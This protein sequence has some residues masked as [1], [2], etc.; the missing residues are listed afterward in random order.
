APLIEGLH[1]IGADKTGPASDDIHAYS[2]FCG[3]DNRKQA[4]SY[5]VPSPCSFFRLNTCPIPAAKIR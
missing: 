3:Y 2:S 1:E 4:P 5:K